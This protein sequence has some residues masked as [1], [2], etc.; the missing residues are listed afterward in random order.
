MN[1]LIPHLEDYE[2]ILWD[3][4]GTLLNDVDI[5][6]NLMKKQMKQYRIKPL[7][8]AEL[9]KHFCF[10]I[11]QY[12]E[13]VGFDLEKECFKTMASEFMDAYSKEM[14]EAKLFHGIKELFET[15]SNKEHFVISASEEKFLHSHVE[16]HG[17]K[18]H[19]TGLY[20]LSDHHGISKEER[21]KELVEEF[22]INPSKSILVGDTAHDAEVAKSCGLNVLLIA[23][24]FHHYDKLSELGVP[25]LETRF[26]PS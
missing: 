18:H 1:T 26:I 7:E 11:R 22:E 8:Q 20:G 13:N 5:A 16:S 9:R 2:N 15:L 4:N 21:C 14:R 10:P 3:W 12:Y 6:F 17:L 25:V 23:D 19:F 24:G